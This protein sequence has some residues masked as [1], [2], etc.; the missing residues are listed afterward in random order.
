MQNEVYGRGVRRHIR[1]QIAQ[2]GMRPTEERMDQAGVDLVEVSSH[3]EARPPHAN[4]EGRVYSRN[5]DKTVGSV[6][7]RDFKT[8][9]NW[10]DVADGI[11]G[12]NCRH[13]YAAWFPGMARTYQPNLEHLSG[14]PNSE[15]YELTQKNGRRKGPYARP[16]A[17]WAARISCTRPP[18][19]SNRSERC[20]G[21][22]SGSETSRRP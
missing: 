14:K 4:W 17:S 19:A 2:D 15:V 21:S 9:Y 1:T 7:Y 18:R 6:Q 3:G 10:G 5:G 8:A 13:S 16:S 20:P 11:G 12:A 22:R